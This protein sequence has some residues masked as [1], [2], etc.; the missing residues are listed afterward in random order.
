MNIFYT[1]DTH[2]G[3]KRTL[4]LSRRPF[5]S[6]EEMDEAMIANWNAQVKSGDLVYHLGDFGNYNVSRRLNGDI[7]LLFGNYERDD[8]EKGLVTLD[9]LRETFYAIY[10]EFCLM[11]TLDLQHIAL[12][13]EP[14]HRPQGIFSLFGHIHEKQ[15]VK[16]NSL[17]VGVD[18]H[19]F[20]PISQ[21]V[22][23]FYREAIQKHYDE[24]V[25]QR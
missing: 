12:V 16:V 11:L 15:L 21:D 7:A 17:N 20:A 23:R 9:T 22:V 5:Q 4:D 14:S 24:E 6:V 1:A 19:H 2:F 13:H 10:K 3:S 18:C 8:L 25:F